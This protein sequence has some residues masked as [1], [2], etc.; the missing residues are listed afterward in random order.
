MYVN[1][2]A[3]YIYI[4]IFKYTHIHMQDTYIARTCI[5]YKYI[6]II[7]YLQKQNN[8]HRADVEPAQSACSY[9]SNRA[10]S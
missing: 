1:V 10:S 6:H 2:Y 4:Y 3:E 8:H 5:I 9:E 7:T